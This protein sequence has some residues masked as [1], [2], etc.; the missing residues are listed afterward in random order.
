MPPT[1]P[2][3]VFTGA[4][5]IQAQY[6]PP[7]QSPQHPLT[8]TARERV[9]ILGSG[10]GGFGVARSL[11]TKHYQ[12]ILITP[13]TYFVFTPLL[14]GTAVGTLEFRTAMESSHSIKGVKVIRGWADSVDFGN[15]SVHIESAGDEA[16]RF[17]LDYDK[18][19]IAVGSYAQTFGIPGVKEHAMFLKD[20]GDARKIRSRVLE[21]FEKASLPTVSEERRKEMLNFAIVGGGP[22]GI[23]FAAELH[24][25]FRDDLV[26]VYPALAEIVKIT[27]YDIAPSILGM[28]DK[29]L[30]VYAENVFRR[31]HIDIRTSHHVL[32]VQA[33]AIVT[34]EDGRVP[35]GAV[36]WS[37]G[38]AT[39]PF[40]AG[41]LG[42]PFL[43][44][45]D[46][47]NQPTEMK[48]VKAPRSGQIQVDSHLRVL[49]EPTSGGTPAPLDD[50]FA[51]G[52]C[53]AI[54]DKHLPATAQV[55]NQQANWLGKSL[56]RA[57]RRKEHGAAD[58]A[59]EKEFRFRSLG[60]MAYLGGWRAITQTDGA[61][62]KGRM[63][64][65]LW[66][67]AYMTKSVSWRNRVLIPTYWFLNWILGR[68]I[69][70]F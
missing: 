34:K 4:G 8:P 62:V 29:K 23:E 64:W 32:E 3:P 36:V 67:T 21:R 69:N 28:F 38:L 57:A 35:V 48:I 7:H 40:V 65:L 52:D 14:A 9:L 70:R 56:N 43:L 47:T 53:A 58:V 39:N 25:L 2:L 68:D 11:D 31:Q 59:E 17:D 49:V 6:I 51:L 37:T 61:D 27:V 19:I 22:T 66:R 44:H 60:V 50:I 63:A 12:P 24:D 1:P 33:D 41:P 13:R 55:A 54:V 10:W 16:V 30:Q 42:N 20:V 45:R 46:Y 18:L 5:R 15:K 26:H